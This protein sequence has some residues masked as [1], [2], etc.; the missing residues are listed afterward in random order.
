MATQLEFDNLRQ[1]IL[2]AERW[3]VTYKDALINIADE[4][5]ELQL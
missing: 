3:T 4:V 1:F 2:Q 5:K